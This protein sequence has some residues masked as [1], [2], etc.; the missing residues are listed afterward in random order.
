MRIL[1]IQPPIEDFFFTRQRAYPLGLLYLAT[2]LDNA[3]FDVKIIN[4]LEN[5]DKRQAVLP[6]NFAY[7]KRYYKLNKSPFCLFS[8]F[9]HYG[10][11]YPALK[12]QIEQFQPDIVGI[13]ANFTAYYIYV[14][15]ICELIKT[16]DK[17]IRV[18][19]GGRVPT[20]CPQEVLNNPNIDWL[21]RGEAELVF[22]NLC[23]A[24][25]QRAFPIEGLCYKEKD[26]L[27]ITDKITIIDDLNQLPIIN[28]KLIKFS[29]YLFRG[30][31]STALI[32]SRGCPNHCAFCAISEK[33]RYR[34]AENVL[35]EINQCYSL[36]IRH[37]NFED[38]NINFNPQFPKLI[39]LLLAKYKGK[40]SISFMNGVMS[41]PADKP[42]TKGLIDLG[43]THLDFSLVTSNQKLRNKLNRQEEIEDISKLSEYMAK[44]KI[45]S[46]IHF[47]LGFPEEKFADCLQDI[48][49]VAKEPAWL[50]PSIFYPVIESS[51]LKDN[52]EL[53]NNFNNWPYF[54]SSAAFFDKDIPRDK[55][56]SL[57]YL[58][59]IINFIKEI[60][61]KFDIRGNFVGFLDNK[62]S[63]IN[64]K[65]EDGYIIIL[66]KVDRI[67][68]GLVILKELLA[69]GKIYRAEFL[70]NKSG[71]YYK[72]LVEEFID[73][74]QFPEV[75]AD[76]QITSLAGKKIR[77]IF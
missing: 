19:V 37:F 31:I 18:L 61:D 45:P 4:A 29:D 51:L 73:H 28:R 48:K 21:I 15:K 47:I 30:Q 52:Q 74:N 33:F 44:E 35:E 13:S 42:I 66:D 40:I 71:D 72:L 70:R 5:N 20:V 12:I 62:I 8:N 54:R 39:D 26:N 65:R 77:G 23:K 6:K 75:F 58:C 63:R 14:E 59:R 17:K 2:V 32:T 11:D 69:T 76:I 36:G 43:L 53:F 25:T 49:N 9:W 41:W 46:T 56:F 16:I 57:F 10:L 64:I 1:L 7:L 55:I 3:G 34:N 22:L 27:R 50:G 60:I 67:D 24:W 68:L 38:D